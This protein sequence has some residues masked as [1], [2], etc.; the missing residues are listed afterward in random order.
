[1]PAVATFSYRNMSD[2]LDFDVESIRRLPVP[3]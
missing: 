1:M 3:G 2:L